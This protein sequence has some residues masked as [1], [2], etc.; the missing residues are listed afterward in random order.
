MAYGPVT[1]RFPE[2]KAFK[3]TTLLPLCLPESKMTTFPGWTDTVD[4]FGWFLFLLK[5]VFSSS[6]GYQVFALFLNLFWAGPPKA[7]ID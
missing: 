5:R 2:A 7:E 1:K 6:A 4:F 3:T